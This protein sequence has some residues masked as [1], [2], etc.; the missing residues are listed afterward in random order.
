MDGVSFQEAMKRLT[1]G[2]ER[3]PIRWVRPGPEVIRKRRLIE[4]FRE[5]EVDASNLYGALRCA[6]YRMI[7]AGGPERLDDHADLVRMIGVLDQYIDILASRD[8][9]RKLAL[10]RAVMA[11]EATDYVCD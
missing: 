3:H 7:Q 10:Y 4:A 6:A 9:R 2:G 1:G 11:G 5:W 8:D